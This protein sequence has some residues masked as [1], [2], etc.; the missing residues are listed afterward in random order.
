MEMSITVFS[1]NSAPC[2]TPRSR[3]VADLRGGLPRAPGGPGSGDGSA[4]AQA[5]SLQGQHH[6]GHLLRRCPETP[7][8]T[9]AK[10][11]FGAE[12]PEINSEFQ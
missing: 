8:K 11:T 10:S 7:Q 5:Q 4:G 12:E 2:L 6:D 3:P 1:C 9:T